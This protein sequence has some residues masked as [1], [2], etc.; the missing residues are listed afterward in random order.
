MLCWLFHIKFNLHRTFSDMIGGYNRFEYSDASQLI[1]LQNFEDKFFVGATS[2]IMLMTDQ[3]ETCAKVTMS[4][5]LQK[6]F[7]DRKDFPPITN[8]VDTD[9]IVVYKTYAGRSSYAFSISGLEFLC[10][11]ILGIAA[12][13]NLDK[14]L[15]LIDDLKSNPPGK[16]TPFSPDEVVSQQQLSEA[17]EVTTQIDDGMDMTKEQYESLFEQYEEE[18]SRL[19]EDILK[20]DI[21]IAVRQEI[22][23]CL[24]PL[25]RSMSD[26]Q[27]LTSNDKAG[28]FKMARLDPVASEIADI[29]ELKTELA[30]LKTELAQNRT[31]L[32]Q[33]QNEV[34]SG[35]AEIQ[36]TLKS[37]FDILLPA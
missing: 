31:D 8:C 27:S 28:A 19:K 6:H 15:T 20:K 14:L 23:K 35:M 29:H 17:P 22:R 26:E 4:R 34:K 18:I 12:A 3:K 32:A 9:Q 25:K 24:N 2:A 30:E 13:K 36:A 16:F 7:V 33:F 11:S 10:G 37:L 1:V 21:V 5:F